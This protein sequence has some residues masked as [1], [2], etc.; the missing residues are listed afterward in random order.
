MNPPENDNAAES[1]PSSAGETAAR[2]AVV[3]G[4]G[5]LKVGLG[6]AGFMLF[7]FA[8]K[9]LLARVV[10]PEHFG[11]F[12]VVNNAV[13]I[14]NNTIVQGTVQSVSKFTAETDAQVEPVKRA[15]LQLQLALGG[16]LAAAFFF[17]APLLTRLVHGSDDYVNWFRLA[18]V[19]PFFY[20]FYAVFVGSVNGQRRFGVQGGFDAAFAALK[21]LLLLVGAATAPMWLHSKSAP[22]TGALLGFA[23]AAGMVLVAA[24]KII[25]VRRGVGPSFPVRRLFSFMTGVFAY[26]LL[27]NVA[28]NYDQLLV[29]SFAGALGDDARANALA[30]NYE[31]LRTLA[32]L[33]YQALIVVTFVIFPLVSRSTFE[34]DGETTRRYIQQ[35]LRISVL[36]AA[37]MG[38][39]LGVRA[40]ALLGIVYPRGYQE[41]VLAL[42]ILAAGQCALALSGIAC[43][44]INA[45]GRPRVAI[46]IMVITVGVG[47]IAAF[48][49]AASV[50]AGPGLLKAQALATTLGM[51]SGLVVAL[52]YL[53]LRYSA[54]V[55]VRTWLRTGAA[56]VVAVAVGRYFPGEGKFAGLLAI[57][58]SAVAYALVLFVLREIDAKD[59][60]QIGRILSRGKANARIDNKN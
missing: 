43:A 46:G 41:G 14:V 25:G 40:D 18:A 36:F 10:G 29:K 5:A 28:L 4:R 54:A 57:G 47:S 45:A 7:G 19:I 20:G 11:A 59:R 27:V 38:L 13:S 24:I 37:V 30:G 58:F 34:A 33:P 50:P 48:N 60:A 39:V 21:T 2:G 49:L 55:P 53:R 31:A 6:K 12:G 16:V 1:A 26:A 51:F 44:M 22:V 3:A 32:L 23:L 56:L 42:P 15:G 35:T 9:W 52:I 8:Q 17:G